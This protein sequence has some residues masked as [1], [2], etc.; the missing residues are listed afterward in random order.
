MRLNVKKKAENLIRRFGTSNPETI[1]GNLGINI[2][3]GHLGGNKYAYYTKYKRV[4]TIIIDDDAIPA[5]LR[6]F[7]LAHE[8]G[9]AVCTPDVNTSWLAA[10]TIGNDDKTERIANKFAVELMLNDKL[11]QQHSEYGILRLAQS[12]GV[13]CELICLKKLSRQR[14]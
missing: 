6:S 14:A 4:K 13:P 9:H 12:L 3:H 5:K 8:L 2:V 7:V 10:Y 1:A 11:L